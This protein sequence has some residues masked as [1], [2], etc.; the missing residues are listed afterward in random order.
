M[1]GGVA[2]VPRTL[3]AVDLK[4]GKLLWDHL[5]DG[6]REFLPLR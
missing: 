6:R 1:D 2:V 5:I 4:S 3:K